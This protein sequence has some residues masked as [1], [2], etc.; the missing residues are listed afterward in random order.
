MYP[1]ILLVE[2]DLDTRMA[3]TCRLNLAGYQVTQAAD[4]ETALE[5]LEQET[6]DLVLTD[7]VMGGIDGIEVLHKARLKPY[8]PAVVLLTGHGT[9]DTCIAAVRAGA[10]DYLMKPCNDEEMMRCI[11]GAVQRYQS[12]QKR[13]VAEYQLLEAA[14]LITTIQKQPSRHG[15]NDIL[16]SRT[17]TEPAPILARVSTQAV[18]VG[19][20]H[21]GGSRHEV[22]FCGEPVQ[23]TPIEYTLLRCLAEKPGETRSY[24]EIV[25]ATHR[26][27]ADEMDA[28]TLVK[29]HIHN[30]RKK[31]EPAYFVNDRGV[32]YR[33]VAPDED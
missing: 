1:H 15:Y 31:I 21:I 28:Q 17:R 2:D 20:L 25:R 19:A 30:L 26:F 14:A 11:E 9:L 29:P 6:F 5:L 23:L 12:E 3:L 24:C 18:Q 13:R 33:I 27:E 8:P 10:Y 22:T 16:V 32:G 4:G 7:I